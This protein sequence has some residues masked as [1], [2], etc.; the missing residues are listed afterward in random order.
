MSMFIKPLERIRQLE[1]ENARLRALVGDAPAAEQQ[2]GTGLEG[3][4]A[5][6]TATLVQ[7]TDDLET[8]VNLIAELMI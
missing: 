8:A 2:L 7:K 4:E 3:A 1:R 5:A 6:A